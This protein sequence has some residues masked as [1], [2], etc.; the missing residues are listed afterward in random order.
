MGSCNVCEGSQRAGERYETGHRG[1]PVP[2]CPG[3]A[4]TPLAKCVKIL[5]PVVTQA[6]LKGGSSQE[7]TRPW[8]GALV[9]VS[10]V[11]IR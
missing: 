11:E 4:C 2:P 5:M 6:R 7:R 3:H 10:G 9:K 8:P 1:Y